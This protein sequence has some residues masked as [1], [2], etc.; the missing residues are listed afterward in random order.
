MDIYN[1][2]IQLYVNHTFGGDHKRWS[3]YLQEW[4]GLNVKPAWGRDQRPVSRGVQWARR[5]LCL[6]LPT[7][8]Q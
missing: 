4:G 2:Y 1:E 6:W 5:R 8:G 3:S 7:T